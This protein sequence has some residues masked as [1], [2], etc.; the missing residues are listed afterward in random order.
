[1]LQYF[2]RCTKL[3]VFRNP[4][5]IFDKMNVLWAN[6]VDDWMHRSEAQLKVN[7]MAERFSLKWRRARRKK[8]LWCYFLWAAAKWVRRWRPDLVSNSAS[9]GHT[10]RISHFL[11]PGEA[12]GSNALIPKSLFL[13]FDSTFL[14]YSTPFAC[15]LF[16][17]LFVFHV[18]ILITGAAHHQS[19]II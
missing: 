1:M 11:F 17:L 15:T 2:S 10:S 7:T 14:L 16:I 13:A 5:T 4:T 9:L 6:T 18:H 12:R 3:W 8:A 19:G